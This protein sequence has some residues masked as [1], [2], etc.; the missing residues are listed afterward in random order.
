MRTNY[1]YAEDAVMRN[2]HRHKPLT[3]KVPVR[4]TGNGARTDFEEFLKRTSLST[5]NEYGDRVITGRRIC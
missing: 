2:R 4:R 1:L 5:L 3:K